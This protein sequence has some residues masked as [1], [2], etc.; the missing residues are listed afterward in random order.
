M[1]HRLQEEAG[2]RDAAVPD[3]EHDDAGHLVGAAIHP[4]AIHP[5]FG[6][7]LIP[8]HR[9]C[10]DAGHQVGDAGEDLNPVTVDLVPT[11]EAACRMSRGL[12]QVILG[13]ARQ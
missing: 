11:G 13:E 8:V 2:R 4:K 1:V 6:P 3:S 7:D 12:V 5:P 9:G 10:Q